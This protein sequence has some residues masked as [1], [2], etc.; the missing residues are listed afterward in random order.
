MNCKVK[1]YYEMSNWYCELVAEYES[2]QAYCDDI[3]LHD[4]NCMAN[5]FEYV[6][7]SLIE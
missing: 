6:T 1:V 7:T 5:R 4:F 3:A 2:E